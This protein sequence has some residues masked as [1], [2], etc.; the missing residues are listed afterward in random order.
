MI[1]KG[2]I[3]FITVLFTLEYE[4]GAVPIDIQNAPP[5]SKNRDVFIPESCGVIEKSSLD[6]YLS[7]RLVVL[8]KDA[9]CNYDA[10]H[11]IS[12]I[13]E[14]LV[15]DY[16]IDLVAVEGAVGLLNLDRFGK[17]G[18]ENAR[19]K[20][21]DEMVK[22]GV[23]TGP[24][25]LSITK[26]GKLS[27]SLRGIE[28]EK[29]YIENFKE[30]RNTIGSLEEAQLFIN[31]LT[32]VV[33]NLK[34][35]I[36]SAELLEFDGKGEKYRDNT[37]PLTDWVKELKLEAGKRVVPLKDYPNLQLTLDAVS[38]EEGI[39]FK[40][41]DSERNELITSLEKVLSKEELKEMI[42]KSLQFK[43]GKIASKDYY[44]YLEKLLGSK[45]I[46]VGEKYSN[47][48]KYIQLVK[49]QTWVNNNLLFTE[50][51]GLE[52]DIKNAMF[53]DDTQ[54]QLNDI[55]KKSEVLNSLFHLTLNRDDLMY[56]KDNRAGFMP[57]ELLKF[58]NIQATA[59]SLPL[60]MLLND[61]NFLDKAGSVIEKG[62]KFYNIA[63]ERDMKLVE[64]TLKVM[65][66]EKKLNAVMVI[67]GFHSDGIVK[68]FEQKG[69]GYIVISPKIMKAEK[70]GL[71][72]SLMMDKRI[73]AKSTLAVP[74]VVADGN[75]NV[76]MLVDLGA[77]GMR[78]E[79]LDVA[80]RMYER[81]LGKKI[82]EP[83]A[84]DIPFTITRGTD[85]RI[86]VAMRYGFKSDQPM[87]TEWFRK[88]LEEVLNKNPE[89][90]EF[91][92]D[93]KN[94]KDYLNK[95]ALI[96]YADRTAGAREEGILRNATV[97]FVS[98]YLGV[99][100]AYDEKGLLGLME[101]FKEETLP[102]AVIDR[103]Y[104]GVNRAMADELAQKMKEKAK[105]LGMNDSAVSAVVNYLFTM[106]VDGKDE[107]IARFFSAYLGLIRDTFGVV[108]GD[109]IDKLLGQLQSYRIHK[110]LTKVD[111]EKIV[112]DSMKRDV[113]VAALTRAKVTNAKGEIDDIDANIA[114]GDAIKG[115]IGDVQLP[116]GSEK[117]RYF[118]QDASQILEFLDLK[119]PVQPF[120]AGIAKL[121][122]K[123]L[124]LCETE[125]QRDALKKRLGLQDNNQFIFVNDYAD[126][127]GDLARDPKNIVTTMLSNKSAQNDKLK[128][129]I[130]GNRLLVGNE[131]GSDPMLIGRMALEVAQPDTV[132]T[133]ELG[134]AYK[135]ILSAYYMGV[136]GE[137]DIEEMAKIAMQDG[138]LKIILPKITPFVR[139]YYNALQKAREA[140]A[141]AA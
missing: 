140:I 119:L 129:P 44:E 21:A 125:Q 64:N 65:E 85:R 118:V 46:G 51:N 108:K 47:L 83:G 104:K 102:Q 98:F 138:M 38:L 49:L 22:R 63:I 132:D 103:E 134:K 106:P 6:K 107:S 127:I 15:R 34:E 70:D 123:E 87:V 69:V 37:M 28:D 110:R 100:K 50:I 42:T 72:I 75:E 8:L 30:F 99:C 11:N 88:G 141:T 111:D 17:L 124:F 58:I 128:Q 1:K 32:R 5:L 97:G 52:G 19:D 117:Q 31:E 101:E 56:F 35:K 13:L 10:Q 43:L 120:R 73:Q 68:L 121:N 76:K 112:T 20:M 3:I 84:A 94:A 114:Y 62:E 113:Y 67:G 126:K 93:P 59:Y 135:K 78:V 2:F 23:L 54:R 39:D 90:A 36:Y 26:Y 81:F 18:N 74:H 41:V 96:E 14:I 60:S 109:E 16:K 77:E 137:K 66:G 82:T 55:S 89:F 57:A 53:K 25:Y 92:M 40:R 139:E 95:K 136:Y 80:M 7:S 79:L 71:Y 116:A 133:A 33:K 12:K 45:D 27:M 9:H 48:K 61:K 131:E 122:G 4:L 29:L 86:S 91:A 24:E 105:A 115:F 130:N